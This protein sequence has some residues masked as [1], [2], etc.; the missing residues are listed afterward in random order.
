MALM[1]WIDESKINAYY[2]DLQWPG[3]VYAPINVKP[4]YP[5][6]ALIGD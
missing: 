6:P 2:I 5:L 4:H 3:M 1:S